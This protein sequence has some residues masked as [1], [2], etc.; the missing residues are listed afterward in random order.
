MNRTLRRTAP[1]TVLSPLAMIL[2]LSMGAC[3]TNSRQV[4]A[5]ATSAQR[6]ALLDPVKSL[7]GEWTMTDESGAEQVASVFTVSSNGSVVR[8]VMFPGQTHEMTNLYHMDGT[9]LVVTH[10][11]AAGNQPRM[12]AQAGPDPMILTF[13][14]DGVSNLTSADETYMGGLTLTRT[15]PDTLVARWTSYVGDVPEGSIDFVLTRKH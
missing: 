13:E 5:P 15:G 6:A 7:E 11:C 8:E 4:V 1:L 3:A 10:Y 2:A 14:R 9:S 12:R